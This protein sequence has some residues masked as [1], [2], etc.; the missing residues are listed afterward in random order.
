MVQ[1]L[2]YEVLVALATEFR[3]A[4]TEQ[5][6]A[7]PL[8][9]EA[10]V[11]AIDGETALEGL[12]A[13][14][15]ALATCGEVAAACALAARAYRERMAAATGSARAVAL[16]VAARVL[17]EASGAAAVDPSVATLALWADASMRARAVGDHEAVETYERELAQMT[18]VLAGAPMV[19]VAAATVPREQGRAYAA[20][21]MRAYPDAKRLWDG[22]TTTYVS[23]A[24]VGDRLTAVVDGG[25]VALLACD[26]VQGPAGAMAV[27]SPTQ[28]PVPVIEV[29]RALREQNRPAYD[30]I[31]VEVRRQSA[32]AAAASYAVAT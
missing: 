5:D 21:V 10:A 14:L 30:A 7:T 18:Q 23:A 1:V 9:G 8:K 32:A 17:L 24:V 19:A 26:A 20:E 31:L 29:L 27:V 11:A 2:A 22:R 6:K 15:P 13:Y 28:L 3:E 12:A 4:H 16:E 25:E